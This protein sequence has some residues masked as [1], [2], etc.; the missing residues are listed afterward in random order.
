MAEMRGTIHHVENRIMNQM[1]AQ[2]DVVISDARTEAGQRSSDIAKMYQ[3][4]RETCDKLNNVECNMA[5]LESNINA[6]IREQQQEIQ[7]Q[8]SVVI[9][10]AGKTRAAAHQALCGVEDRIREMQVYMAER[11]SQTEETVANRLIELR[12]ELLSHIESLSADVG[13]VGYD[14]NRIVVL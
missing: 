6:K 10:Y 14:N 9:S 11:E 1:Q 13:V 7:S 3:A 4:T 2:I 12:G 8:M 5:H